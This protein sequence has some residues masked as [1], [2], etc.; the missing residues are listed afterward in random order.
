MLANTMTAQSKIQGRERMLPGSSMGN[1]QFLLG[2]LHRESHQHHGNFPCSKRNNEIPPN[3][4]A[5][6]LK[7]SLT[8][9][10]GLQVAHSIPARE[11]ERM[12]THYFLRSVSVRGKGSKAFYGPSVKEGGACC[13]KEA[14]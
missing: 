12:F 3:E 11:R 4:T 8:G 6:L 7:P 1:W 9:E 10:M 14:I 5:I 2:F 13:E